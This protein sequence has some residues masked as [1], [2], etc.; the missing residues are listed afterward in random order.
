M[1]RDSKIFIVIGCVFL[2]TAGALSAFGFHGPDDILTPDKRES[3]AWA[4]EMQY[5]H[6]LGLILVGVLANT[7]GASWFI[8]AAGI[9]MIGGILVFSFLVY[10]GA[11]GVL[12][13]LSS[14]IP[15]GGMMLMLSWASLAIGA[16]TAKK[17]SL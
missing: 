13:Q 7:L 11:L 6:G 1:T 4:V 9:L 8:S 12:E 2:A 10:A 14:I 16:L 15:Y 17:S 5:Y 3:W